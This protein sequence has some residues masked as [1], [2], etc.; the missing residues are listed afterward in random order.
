MAPSATETVVPVVEALKQKAVSQA[1]ATPEKAPEDLNG[2]AVG[3]APIDDA[4]AL[5]KLEIN[6]RE[7]LKL[8][9]ALEQFKYF[10]NTPV[11][12]REYVDVDLA[13][14]LRAP[15]SDELIRDLAITISRRGVVFFRKQ[16]NITNDLQKELVQRLGEL[17]GKPATS[18]LHIHPIINASRDRGGQDN[19]IS[20]IS[21]VQNR[22]LYKRFQQ[23][24]SGYN[25]PQSRRLEWHSDITFEPVPSDYALLRLV[26]LPSTGGAPYSLPI[27]DADII[28]R[29]VVEPGT[30]G[31]SAIVKNFGPE[32]LVP[33]SESMPESGIDGKG[34]PLNRPA[35][36]RRVFGEGEE[37][38][39]S[40]G[41]LN[42]IVHP[43]VRKEI[44]RAILRH[45]LKGHWA[46]VLDVPLLFE[47]GW[48]KLSGVVMVVAVKDPELQMKRLM[49]RD[50]HLSAE[51][52]Q[53]RVLSQTDV[54]LKA[55]RCEARGK[56]R[57]VV[58]WNDG[59]R[60][61]L[62]ANIDACLQEI[63]KSSPPWW[64]W[65]CLLFPPLGVAAGAWTYWQNIQLNKKWQDLE[66]QE[67]A[68]L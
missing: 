52:A 21:S 16:D 6:H 40:R 34:R 38:K 1:D 39:K 48:D 13:E 28:A 2:G 65:L 50:P 62:R 60:E 56:G 67:K 41:V 20:V 47:S 30:S 32:I 66:L 43:A 51:D 19:E 61:E 27:I 4:F 14:W 10:D 57:G 24:Q 11:I 26:E 23:N 54:R 7:P 9:G 44:Y 12:G 42:G 15:N 5:P 64:N 68:R 37:Q 55:K 63:R 33:V 45:Y 31:Y 46:V 29:Q 35:L 58:V 59:S 25:K 22:K 18:G 17:S 49:E 3:S 53:N 36:G 8:S